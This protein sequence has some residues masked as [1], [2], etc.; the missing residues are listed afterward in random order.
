MNGGN[1]NPPELLSVGD[2]RRGKVT[3][4]ILSS[5]ACFSGCRSDEG[6]SRHMTWLS[7]GRAHFV[8]ESWELGMSIIIWALVPPCVEGPVRLDFWLR[9]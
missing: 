6:Q 8:R 3:S 4:S 5:I 2:L 7:A 9:L 1:P